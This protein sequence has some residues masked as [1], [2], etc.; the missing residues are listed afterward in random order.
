MWQLNCKQCD[1]QTLC[2]LEDA[3]RRLRLVGLLRRESEPDRALVVELFT[4]NARRMTCPFCKSRGLTAT[5]ADDAADERDEWQTAV[6]CEVCR[7]PIPPERLDVLPH[8]RRC[9][10]C[11]SA[12]ESG[13]SVDDEPEFCPKCGALVELRVSRGAGLTRY[14]S[15]C[16][17]VPPCRL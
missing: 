9:V 5:E 14:R 4:R 13:T 12:T 16:T 11:Q 1:W 6:L 15:F 10:K 2:D 3:V 7:E 17:G 8:A